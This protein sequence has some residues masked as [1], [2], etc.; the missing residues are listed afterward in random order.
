MTSTIKTAITL[1][2]ITVLGVTLL[3]GC[4]KPNGDKFIGTWQ[5]PEHDK[6]GNDLSM[7][8]TIEK[9]DAIYT[10]KGIDNMGKMLSTNCASGASFKDDKLVCNSQFNFGYNEKTDQIMPSIGQALSRVKSK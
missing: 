4:S 5:H 8:I 6:W 3:S 1:G 10:V 7:T 9:T 2:L